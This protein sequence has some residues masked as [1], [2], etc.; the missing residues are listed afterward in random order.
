MKLLSPPPSVFFFC[1]VVL[2]LVLV[3]G[4]MIIPLILW[5]DVPDMY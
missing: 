1:V 5:P 2:V 4:A 3:L